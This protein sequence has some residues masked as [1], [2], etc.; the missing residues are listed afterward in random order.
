[1]VKTIVKDQQF[2]VNS[3]QLTLVNTLVNTSQHNTQTTCV[4][5]PMV[6]ASFSSPTLGQHS[7]RKVND[8]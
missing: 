4:G 8:A 7:P 5:Q 1:M 2:V 6:N 3:N